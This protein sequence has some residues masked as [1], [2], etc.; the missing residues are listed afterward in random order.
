VDVHSL[1]PR[2][3][4]GYVLD[5]SAGQIAARTVVLATGAYQRPHRPAL[6]GALPSRILVMDAEG[7]A[8][9]EDL[10]AGAVLVVG[11]GQTG[12]QISEELCRA[13]RDVYLSCGRAPWLP[14][15]VEGRDMMAWL[16]DTSF[17]EAPLSALPSPEARLGANVQLSGRDG[18]HD[19]NFRTLHRMGVRLVG[20]L[21]DVDGR[22]A[23]F[24]PDL[25]ESVAFG[26]AR[27]LEIRDLIS[28]QL[29][30]RGVAPPDLPIPPPFQA[31]TVTE[32]PLDGIA[33]V[34]FTCGFRPDYAS[35]VHVP[36]FD[37]MG[38]PLVSGCKST[39]APDL[40]FVGVHFLRKRKSSLLLGVG[41]DAGLA[42]TAIAD[43]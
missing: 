11:S 4:G 7:Y 24:A 25:A 6:A 9:P 26:D 20:R 17:F 10:P 19:L 12:C 30:E 16:A 31:P 14:R 32:L 8:N 36:G 2:P 41:E 35:W 27:Y 21:T 33:T 18:G 39:V 22:R 15:T 1:D 37:A 34:I 29:R 3:G 28:N 40:Y 43:S 23:L 13:G 5:T 42:A 38:F